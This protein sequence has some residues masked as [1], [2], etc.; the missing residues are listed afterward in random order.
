MQISLEIP[1]EI[2]KLE[3]SEPHVVMDADKITYTYKVLG[4]ATF[5]ADNLH[6]G[7]QDISKCFCSTL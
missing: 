2:K 7:S 1:F 6:I 5:S 3:D 4:K